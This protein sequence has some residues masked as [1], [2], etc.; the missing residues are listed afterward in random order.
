MVIRLNKLNMR[1]SLK[2]RHSTLKLF[3]YL[4]YMLALWPFV[5]FPTRVDNPLSYIKYAADAVILAITV[6]SMR[7]GKIKF[8]RCLKPFVVICLIFF[9][10]TLMGHLFQFQY[11]TYYLWGFRNLFRFYLAFFAFVRIFNENHALNWLKIMDIVFWINIGFSLVQYF[12]LGVRQDNLGG[13]LGTAGGTNGCTMLF[14]SIVLAKS[15]LSTFN[16]AEKLHQCFL[17][18]IAA[19]LVCA[20]AELKFFFFLFVFIVL[21]SAT[22]TRFSWKK[23]TLILICAMLVF[24]G[25]M[26]LSS[27]FESFQGFFSLERLWI[28]ATQ[29]NYSSKNDLNRLSAIFVLSKTVM[30]NPLQVLFGLGLGNC[31]T[32]AFAICNT[33]FF[34][35]HSYLHYHYFAAPMIYLET[36]V[37]GLVIYLSFFIT[38]LVLSYRE[39]RS[40][41]GNLLLNQLAIIISVVCMINTFYDATMRNEAAYMAYFVL[42]M[43]YFR[44]KTGGENSKMRGIHQRRTDNI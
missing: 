1:T 23:V 18:C 9:A 34:E 20:F 6:V 37:V 42:A 43:P 13:I 26:I 2:P 8:R 3:R 7:F 36:G 17:K 30:T 28:Q 32:S 5:T 27:L 24:W 15:L 33:P 29:M 39:Y 35:S 41:R 19:L 10:Y 40:G 16:G 11:P 12:F 25:V 38:S 22:L 44:M 4:L 21:I 31:D 14:F